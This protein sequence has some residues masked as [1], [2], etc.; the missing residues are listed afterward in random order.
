MGY[1][2]TRSDWGKC[3]IDLVYWYFWTL[4]WRK[5][6]VA[7]AASVVTDPS[8]IHLQCL[9]ERLHLTHFRRA[10]W[11]GTAGD[12]LFLA[13]IHPLVELIVGRRLYRYTLPATNRWRASMWPIDCVTATQRHSVV[14]QTWLLSPRRVTRQIVLRTFYA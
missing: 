11:H 3:L 7:G 12:V 1:V 9:F 10:S 14:H 8:G 5:G 4:Y 6:F 2:D 13:S